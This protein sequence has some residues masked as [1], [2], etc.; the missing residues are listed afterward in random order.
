MERPVPGP[1]GGAPLHLAP[2]LRLLTWSQAN[3]QTFAKAILASYE[4]TLD[5]P[6]LLG[7]RQIDDIIA[8]HMATGQFVPEL[9]MALYREEEPAAV[10]LLGA[11]PQRQAL[12]LVYL[13]V[14][15]PFRR[16][17]MARRLVDHAIH[18]AHRRRCNKLMLAVDEH[19]SPALK[20]Y[21]SMH[22]IA[23]A[24]RTALVLAL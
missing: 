8:G 10:M 20:L 13:G 3:R 17:G 14:S 6:G 4:Q 19:N 11:L 16:Q 12:E 7:M 24:R 23:T 18:L 21:R 15:V 22:F 2:P 1:G 9:W 5:C